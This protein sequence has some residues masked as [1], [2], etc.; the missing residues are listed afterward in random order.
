M[1]TYCENSKYCRT[2]NFSDC[3]PFIQPRSVRGFV[4]NA[5]E[6]GDGDSTKGTGTLQYEPAKKSSSVCDPVGVSLADFLKQSGNTDDAFGLTR[7]SSDNIVFPAVSVKK[8]ILEKT[9]ASMQVS[10]I[11]LQ[12]QT[13][14]DKGVVILQEDGGVEHNYCPKGKYDRHWEITQ[15]GANK[16]KEGEQEHCN[17]FILAFNSSL[18]K[19]RDAVN[20][21]GTK[22]IK[23][24]SEKEAKNYLKRKTKVHPDQWISTF[25]CLASKTK[26][27]DE[28]NWHLPKFISPRVDK[29]CTKAV[30]RFQ[31]NNLPEVGKHGSDEIIKDC[32]PAK[33]K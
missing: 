24:G 6:G 14:K 11:F 18:A 21:A 29:N 33:K 26:I 25:W 13:F 1:K 15:G 5:D 30:I 19:Y 31:S 32:E 8:G 9:D 7:L 2:G 10:S 4:M 17:D 28:M 20:E 3:I 12:A 27:R 23:F 16:I 22:K